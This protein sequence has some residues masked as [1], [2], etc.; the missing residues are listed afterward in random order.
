MPEVKANQDTSNVKM[1]EASTEKQVLNSIQG[2]DANDEHV[3]SVP[4]A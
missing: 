3:F 1:N 4:D 2:D